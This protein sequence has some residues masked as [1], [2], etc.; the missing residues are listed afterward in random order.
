MVVLESRLRGS[1]IADHGGGPE[2]AAHA[3]V[4]GQLAS[5]RVGVHQ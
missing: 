5:E 1:L 4:T 3:E 2:R